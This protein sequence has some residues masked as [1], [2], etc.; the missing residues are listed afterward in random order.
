MLLHAELY[1]KC[2][3]N[4]SHDKVQKGSAYQSYIPC[5]RVKS[6]CQKKI[7]SSDGLW[8]LPILIAKR[9]G[10]QRC[11][12]ILKIFRG[13]KNLFPKR[14]CWKSIIIPSTAKAINLCVN[15]A[16]Y[17]CDRDS[18]TWEIHGLNFPLG[19]LMSLGS[20]YWLTFLGEPFLASWCVIRSHAAVSLRFLYALQNRRW[21]HFEV[22]KSIQFVS[23][24]LRLRL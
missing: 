11:K 2:F 8:L 22:Y 9:L 4:G 14:L 5:D 21:N 20:E 3:K 19:D 15:R 24:A 23:R 1:P 7:L 10:Y 12:R 13:N 17:L 6:W 18:L 16:P